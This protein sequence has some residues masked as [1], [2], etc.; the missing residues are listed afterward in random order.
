MRQLLLLRRS[1]VPVRFSSYTVSP[2]ATIAHDSS[3]PP[4]LPENVDITIAGGG[5][6]GSAMALA[7]GK[8]HFYYSSSNNMFIVASS[9]IF[10]NHKIVLLES[11]SKL[12]KVTKN[13][14]YSNRVCALNNQ[15]INL[16]E[17][18]FM[19]KYFV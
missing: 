6:V 18:M 16:F 10:K 15:T 3:K 9:P 17:S 4:T 8:I 7:F 5:L 2:K 1:L 13:Q 12:P 11:Q 19:F 14:P